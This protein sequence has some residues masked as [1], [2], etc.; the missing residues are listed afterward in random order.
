MAMGFLALASAAP[1]TSRAAEDTG[2]KV[3][4]TIRLRQEELDG[5]FRPGFRNQ[6]DVLSI[7]SSLLLEWDTGT[8]RF[9]GEIFDGRE[10]DTGPGSVLSTNEVD[11]LEPAQAYVAGDFESPFGAGSSAMVQAGRFTMN[12]GSRRLISADEFRNTPQA[13]TGLRSELKFS[14][15][16][17]ATLFYVLPQQHRPDDFDSLLKNKVKLD[18]EGRDL[19]VFGAL[20]SKAGLPG[21]LLA[22]MGF[23]RFIEHDTA[24]RPTRNRGLTNLTA[25]LMSDPA[26][27][28]WDY[29][30][31]GI[32]Q[33]GSIRAST[34]ANAVPLRVRA[35][36]AHADLGYTFAQSWKPHL[37]VEWDYASGDGTSAHY[38]RFDTLFGMRRGEFGPSGIYAAVGRANIN[39]LGLRLDGAPT[40]R[41][42]LLA[43]VK[44]LWAADRHDSFSTTG[45]RDAS[46]A[47]GSFAGQQL[48]ARLRYWFLPQRLRGEMNATW[49][50]RG[51]LLQDAPN[52]SPHGDTHYAAAAIT[53]T[54]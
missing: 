32:S 9:G 50:I 14:G 38:N 51:R 22:E 23:I 8:W 53:L 20:F 15:K 18:H 40:K 1:G 4:G 26:P 47:S 37:D 34:A 41:L 17:S 33:T 29:E 11:A 25:R 28:K 45:I 27:G 21:R 24:G 12:L 36:F 3:S 44:W 39:T 16:R 13:S 5:D 31:E 42:D 49:L 2:F 52:A 6:D 30:L 7:R 43:T 48:D 54:F 19:Q 46:G 10:Y 35:Y